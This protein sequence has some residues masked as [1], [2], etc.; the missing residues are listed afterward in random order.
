MEIEKSLIPGRGL[1][2]GHAPT[3]RQASAV[4]IVCATGIIREPPVDRDRG[5]EEAQ[6]SARVWKEP[7][8]RA[9]LAAR[10]PNLHEI[11]PEPIARQ[12]RPSKAYLDVWYEP[13]L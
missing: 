11:T 4:S 3:V 9:A 8:V 2:A 5:W 12:E 13:S 1:Q 7:K 10:Q 6:E